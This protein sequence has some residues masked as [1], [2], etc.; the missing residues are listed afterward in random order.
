MHEMRSIA[1]DDPGI[2]LSVTHSVGH[3]DGLCKNGRTDQAPVWGG[4]ACD[5]R[6]IVLDGGPCPSAA[7]GSVFDAAFAKLLW[8]LVVLLIYYLRLSHQYQLPRHY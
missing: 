1:T 4:D 5:P 2:C 6:N 8:P 7:R 3:A